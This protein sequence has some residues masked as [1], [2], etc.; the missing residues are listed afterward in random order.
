MIQFYWKEDL[1]QNAF[2]IICL[3]M[4]T[5]LMH[6]LADYSLQG[7]LAS[8]KQ[9]VWWEKNAPDPMYKNDWIAGLV[10][11]SA[12]WGLLCAVPSVVACW[13]LGSWTMGILTL[14]LMIISIVGHCFI[15][16]AKA[17]AH[18][19]NLIQDQE[20][21]LVQLMILCIPSVIAILQGG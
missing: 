13:L 6:L 18:K 10:C 16:T 8:M 19:I 21:H 3:L 2:Y 15:D 4:A 12:M 17:N 14:A 9:K 7:I 11:H 1:M 5:V 20:L